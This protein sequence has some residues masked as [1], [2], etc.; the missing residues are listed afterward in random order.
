[1]AGQCPRLAAPCPSPRHQRADRFLFLSPPK[2]SPRPSHWWQ[3]AAQAAETPPAAELLVVILRL[4]ATAV[5][6]APEVARLA[7]VLPITA[8]H[9]VLMAPVARAPMAP[10]LQ[11]MR[12]PALVMFPEARMH[13]CQPSPGKSRNVR[14]QNS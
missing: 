2:A 7:Q 4:A 14:Q 1:M 13:P 6:A 11:T 10:A 3:R 8:A 9:L 5:A 12:T